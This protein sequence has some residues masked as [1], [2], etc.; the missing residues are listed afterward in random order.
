[1]TIFKFFLI[2]IDSPKINFLI[3]SGE[4]D[5]LLLSYSCDVKVRGCSA[6]LSLIF[7]SP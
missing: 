5:L 7:N 6:E 3:I 2:K 1:M 4:A